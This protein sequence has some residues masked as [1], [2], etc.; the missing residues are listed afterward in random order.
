MGWH[1]FLDLV[2]AGLR[3]DPDKSR[4]DYMKINAELYGVDL[5]DI[6]R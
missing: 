4:A 5:N 6:Q 1:T 2:E 3:G